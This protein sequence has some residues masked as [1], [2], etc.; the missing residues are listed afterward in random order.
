M[1]LLRGPARPEALSPR[2]ILMLAAVGALGSMAIHMFVPAM[3][4][5]A[6]DLHVAADTTQ[7]A[8]TLYLIGLGTGQLLAGP[9]V[10]RIGRRPVLL[11]GLALFVAGAA[12]CGV[13]RSAPLLLGA[14]LVQ[15]VGGAAGVVT[16]R[17][18]VSDLAEPRE[19]AAKM[20]LLTSVL[21]LSPAVAPVVGGAVASL[22]GWRA[23]FALL[24]L[25]GVLAWIV[26]LMR[27]GETRHA[28]S[29]SRTR[30][31]HDY[32]RL[33]GN[34]R[35]LRYAAAIAG[36]SCT[37]YIFL[38]SS[39]FLLIDRYGLTPAQAGLCYF[40]V[41]GA[42]ITGS[43]NVGRFE[44]RGG[45]FRFGLFT[46]SVGALAM[47]AVALAGGD[48]VFALIVPMIAVGLGTGIAAP[49]GVAGAMHVEPGLAG[50]ATS[51][52]GAL[53]MLASGI[54]ASLIV[55]VHLSTLV[56]LAIALS[57]TALIGLAAAPHGPAVGRAQH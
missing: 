54:T 1:T 42:G 45:A 10:D 7:L 11:A 5:I 36:S 33:L 17:A 14:R 57:G 25:A 26:T 53:Q 3:P 28:P 4:A 31:H 41:A 32:R 51:L 48:G 8:V 21:L 9:A 29:E 55:Q 37:L 38:S 35:F 44:A 15:A 52:V 19:I 49:A 24:A 56:A 18:I 12:L 43:L 27:I 46:A 50:T 13:A 30:L 23:I 20:G 6:R 34:P 39:A 47:L 22:A 40:L 16:I 2:L